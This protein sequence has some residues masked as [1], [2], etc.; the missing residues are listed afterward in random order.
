MPPTPEQLQIDVNQN[1]TPQAPQVVAQIP[2]PTYV[3]ETPPSMPSPEMWMG[4]IDQGDNWWNLGSFAAKAGMDIYQNV[5]N[6][7]LTNRRQIAENDINN[8]QN[9]T[10]EKP[11]SPDL[12]PA[13]L[14]EWQLGQ[15]RK[16]SN[17]TYIALINQGLSSED[18]TGVLSGKVNPAGLK[19][20][21]S[22]IQNILH[23][24]RYQGQTNAVM[25]NEVQK[26]DDLAFENSTIGFQNNNKN[27]WNAN[28]NTT[29]DQVIGNYHN[30]VDDLVSSSGLTMNEILN[31]DTSKLSLFKKNRHAV[32]NQLLKEN[33][34]DQAVEISFNKQSDLFNETASTIQEKLYESLNRGLITDDEYVTQALDAHTKYEKQNADLSQKMSEAHSIDS[35]AIIQKQQIEK[36]KQNPSLTMRIALNQTA[37]LNFEIGNIEEA[38][39]N[40][41]LKYDEVLLLQQEIKNKQV[42]QFKIVRDTVNAV[43][44]A[45]LNPTYKAAYENF[46]SMDG[47]NL[48]VSANQNIQQVQAKEASEVLNALSNSYQESNILTELL[49]KYKIK[50]GGVISKEQFLGVLHITKEQLTPTQQ[51]FYDVLPT[52]E[53]KINSPLNLVD[54]KNFEPALISSIR[55]SIAERF[56]LPIRNGII[57]PRTEFENELA[58]IIM[59]AKIGS[60]TKGTLSSASNAIQ[61][62][63]KDSENIGNQNKNTQTGNTLAQGYPGVTPDDIQKAGPIAIDNITTQP[64]SS[65]GDWAIITAFEPRKDTDVINYLN[66]EPQNLVSAFESVLKNPTNI[67]RNTTLRD[68][69]KRSAYV[70]NQTSK[71]NGVDIKNVE[72]MRDFIN[73]TLTKISMSDPN[74]LT[75]SQETQLDPVIL[76]QEFTQLQQQ[77]ANAE[78]L[79][80]KNVQANIQAANSGN[81]DTA[82]TGT[83][84][85]YL[86]GRKQPT[87][88]VVNDLLKHAPTGGDIARQV[89]DEYSKDVLGDTYTSWNW[90]GF[91]SGSRVTNTE[92]MLSLAET[93]QD[94]IFFPIITAIWSAGP[95]STPETIRAEAEKIYQLGGYRHKTKLDQDGTVRV[96]SSTDIYDKTSVRGTAASMDNMDVDAV[97]NPAILVGQ[98]F[99][100]IKY[101]K[102][103]PNLKVLAGNTNHDYLPLDKKNQE[104]YTVSKDNFKDIVRSFMN[105]SVTRQNLESDSSS[106]LLIDGLTDLYDKE[107]SPEE[108]Q[109]EALNPNGKLFQWLNLTAGTSPT[110]K[111]RD[112]KASWLNKILLKSDLTG[113]TAAEIGLNSHSW[114]GFKKAGTLKAEQESEWKSMESYQ[115][116]FITDG[117]YKNEVNNLLPDNRT[118]NAD[119]VSYTDVNRGVEVI[120]YDSNG[121]EK[122][123]PS[124]ISPFK[125]AANQD[126]F[127]E[128]PSD[129][130]DDNKES[131]WKV[132]NVTKNEFE[133]VVISPKTIGYV[134][135]DSRNYQKWDIVDGKLIKT[136][137]HFRGKESKTT[138]LQTL[139]PIQELKSSPY[140]PIIR[141]NDFNGKP[142]TPAPLAPPAPVVPTQVT[143]IPVAPAPVET[144]D[145]KVAKFKAL[146]YNDEDIRQMNLKKDNK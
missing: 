77:K 109:Q 31:S 42:K 73:F 20:Y 112:S 85:S 71:T 144:Y 61:G 115:G 59:E 40:P 4:G 88:L 105:G 74:S 116:K 102:L 104:R 93:S 75:Y 62:F 95:D 45:D 83:A 35:D 25:Q 21:D 113:K 29:I 98:S 38:L 28:D 10:L 64:M 34:Y 135:E 63:N 30:S 17:N 99:E 37:Q 24:T 48:Q 80:L 79:L 2:T 69:R 114:I 23:L 32:V 84:L 126:S 9:I 122:R 100:D 46:V 81:A 54:D 118:T 72:Q 133:K 18:A 117:N 131:T 66:A 121:R 97:V 128:L 82:V 86:A 67:N 90:T 6:A 87:A 129:W 78:S 139:I 15:Q 5:N 65:A 39:T 108:R 22:D 103:L 68:N 19:M 125:A 56:G 101:R 50:T 134:G 107:L 146:G 119:G 106:M 111:I 92:A 127:K 11:E 3:A 123:M 52:N 27:S 70:N 57:V 110:N 55:N 136:L 130:V 1:A 94:D 14:K 13:Q 143:P 43:T 44:G 138:E 33:N 132:W 7:L 141:T 8:I 96:I 137:Y 89:F 145:E 41:N 124:S 12:T 58:K 26:Y 47:K 53:N 36:L 76:A 120:F 51:Y 142:V 91:Y 60:N 16:L 140:I 49:S